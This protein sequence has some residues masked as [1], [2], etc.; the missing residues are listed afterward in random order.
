MSK[1]A[2]QRHG[3]ARRL[4]EEA[5]PGPWSASHGFVFM[6]DGQ[7]F[8]TGHEGNAQFIAAARELIPQLLDDIEWWKAEAGKRADAAHVLAV[9][10]AKHEPDPVEEGED[11]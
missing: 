4:C 3:Y 9:R 1:T 11:D 8:P 2:H 6:S 7:T 5:T 10:L